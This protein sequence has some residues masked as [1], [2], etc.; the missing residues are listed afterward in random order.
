MLVGPVYLCATNSGIRGMSVQTMELDV[1]K[2]GVVGDGTPA[3]TARMQAVINANI[4]ATLLVRAGTALTFGPLKIPSLTHLRIDGT[5]RLAN[6][7]NYSLFELT[8][9]EGVRLD[10]RGTLDGNRTG[11]RLIVGGPPPYSACILAPG[12]LNPA[13]TPLRGLMVEGL[14]LA[15]A[16]H[17]PLSLEN[18]T[19]ARVRDVTALASGDS[20]QFTAGCDDCIADGVHID[21]IGDDGFAF[22][23]G[24]TNS[25]LVNSTVSRSVAGWVA[26]N[27]SGSPRPCVAIVVANCIFASNQI[28]GAVQ[29]GDGGVGMHEAVYSDG[30]MYYANPNGGLIW[31]SCALGQSNDHFGPG[32]TKGNCVVM[33]GQNVKVI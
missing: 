1:T 7:S 25:K 5:V 16:F 19:G 9:G 13:A 18:V 4:G 32:N 12:R 20:F 28:G 3:D 22:Y 27:D 10:G 6:G 8:G 24:V 11:Q 29:I 2:E 15:N 26:L 30:N 17:W 21:S 23:G 31:S 33:P 14:T